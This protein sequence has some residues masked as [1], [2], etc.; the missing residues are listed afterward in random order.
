MKQT[1]FWGGGWGWE[2]KN[3]RIF[4]GHARGLSR[5]NFF[6][7]YARKKNLSVTPGYFYI[8]KMS[9]FLLFLYKSKRTR[10]FGCC[11]YKKSKNSLIF[12]IKYWG[13][14]D[15][16]LFSR[17]REKKFV[18]DGSPVKPNQKFVC[19]FTTNRALTISA[20]PRL[21]HSRMT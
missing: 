17:L 18:R 11:F 1:N 5:T 14:T 3:E 10:C 16:F 13:G 8:S 6:S 9:E 7:C 12:D 21:K 15:K 4:D 20:D 2:G 19:S